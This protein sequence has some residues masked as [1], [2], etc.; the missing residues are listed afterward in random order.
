MATSYYVESTVHPAE[1]F[2]CL[3][4]FLVAPLGLHGRCQRCDSD[5][6]FQTHACE[7]MVRQVWL[8]RETGAFLPAAD[9][10]VMTG[11]R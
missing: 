6:V 9:D 5:A 10:L 7:P 11:P 4:C 8:K 1:E 3:D 2:E